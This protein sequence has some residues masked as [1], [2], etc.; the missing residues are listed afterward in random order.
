MTDDEVKHLT[1]VV[2]KKSADWCLVS[3]FVM[4]A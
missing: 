3:T 2:K 1:S 4:I